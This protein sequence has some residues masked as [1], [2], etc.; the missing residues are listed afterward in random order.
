MTAPASP[1]GAL[2]GSGLK[3]HAVV[4]FVDEAGKLRATVRIA[5]LGEQVES[6]VLLLSCS[7]LFT[8]LAAMKSSQPVGHRG[9][10]PRSLVALVLLR[11]DGPPLK[12]CPAERYMT[13]ATRPGC[14]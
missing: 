12:A 14:L 13:P 10:Q 11:A 7:V 6:L 2:Q 5:E 1:S 9:V 3:L 8:P 4:V